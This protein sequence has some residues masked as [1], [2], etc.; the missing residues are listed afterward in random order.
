MDSP[1]IITH[2][3]QMEDRDRL[4]RLVGEHLLSRGEILFAYAHGSFLQEPHFRDLDI[5]VFLE[6]EHCRRAG[7]R[8]ET[9]LEEELQTRLGVPFPL[10]VRLLN[11]AP[12]SFQYKAIGGRLLVDRAPDLRVEFCTRVMSRYLDIR[13]VLLHHMR[14]AFSYDTGR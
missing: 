3:M 5:A 12:V 11:R 8:Y 14:E 9:D 13:P 10:D 2:T 6:K 7:Y 1:G 4:L